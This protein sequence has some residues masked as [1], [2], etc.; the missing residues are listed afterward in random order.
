MKTFVVPDIHGRYDS[1]RALLLQAGVINEDD[2]RT[3]VA[4]SENQRIFRVVSIG[5]L[6]N[7]TL[8]DVNGDEQCLSK[9][10]D[11]FDYLI[12]GNH[13]SGYLFTNMGFNGYYE[14]PHLKSLYCQLEREGIV[15]PAVAIGNTLLT[16]AGVHEYF[17]F[18]T[19][20]EA[21]DAIYDVWEN[22]F[23]YQDDIDTKFYFRKQIEIPK[24]LLLDAVSSRRGGATPFG[25]FLWSDWQE[26]KNVKFN[27]IVG[28]TPVK[29]GPIVTE[30]KGSGVFHANIDCGAKKGLTPWGVWLD[31]DGQIEEFVTVADDRVPAEA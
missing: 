22:Y 31:E 29:Y 11:W 1:L 21:F 2:Q 15:V 19:A 26:P 16:H 20:G 18:G 12:L 3:D 24:A 6:A 10:R 4:D 7:A 13:E 14:A 9:A 17:E 28:H 30:F 23:R 5:D 8:M 27:Q 25:G